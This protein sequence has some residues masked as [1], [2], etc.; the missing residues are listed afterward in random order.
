MS[1]KYKNGVKTPK[2]YIINL[3]LDFRFIFLT[4]RSLES[5]LLPQPRWF[6]DPVVLCPDP[7]W[8]PTET[9]LSQRQMHRWVTP[10][11][12]WGP[13]LWWSFQPVAVWFISLSIHTF[14]FKVIHTSKCILSQNSS[15]DLIENT[16]IRSRVQP[17]QTQGS[18]G[19]F[20]RDQR[21][22]G[23]WECWVGYI[24]FY[25]LYSNM[26]TIPQFQCSNV[27]VFRWFLVCEVSR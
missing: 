4:C 5:Q 18:A 19:R 25:L 10:I 1:R 13:G 14:G 24:L 17:I 15:N 20:D 7:R 6:R 21:R 26:P 22:R 8:K 27:P 3:Y 12:I 23:T 2:Y 16:Q 11:L 9:T